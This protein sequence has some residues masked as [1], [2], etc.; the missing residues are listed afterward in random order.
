MVHDGLWLGTVLETYL[1]QKHVALWGG[2]YQPGW[3]LLSYLGYR[4]FENFL[5]TEADDYGYRELGTETPEIYEGG[6]TVSLTGETWGIRG[7]TDIRRLMVMG[8]DTWEGTWHIEGRG[9]FQDWRCLIGYGNRLSTI[10]VGY[11]LWW[12]RYLWEIGLRGEWSE[13]YVVKASLSLWNQSHD[14]GI[15][16]TM[17]V[18]S[19]YEKREVA[20]LE[21]KKE[22]EAWMIA[23]EIG[24]SVWDAGRIQI[25]LGK[26]W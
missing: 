18:S 20:C 23:G 8:Y 17:D 10:H 19:S 6:F 9:R 7:S 24:L 1:G 5:V 3:H 21:W 16:W 22:W 14:L 12:H 13:G 11:S 2:F 26:R 25:R 15:G 4:V